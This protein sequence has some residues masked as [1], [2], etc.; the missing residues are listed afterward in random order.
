[1]FYSKR[2]ISKK[3]YKGEK[4]DISYILKNGWIRIFLST[5]LTLFIIFVMGFLY[6]PQ[7]NIVKIIRKEKDKN[8]KQLECAETFQKMKLINLIFLIVN[9]VLMILFWIFLSLFCY[10]YINSIID[11]IFGSF[12]TW[13]LIQIF[14]FFGVLI[15]TCLRFMGLK[16]GSECSF[17]I[18]ICFTI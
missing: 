7:K 5:L 16:F 6:I 1:M 14:P 3:H 10:V 4:N 12:I 9:F 15:V 2:Y 18:S 11:W 8:I 17:K 13:I